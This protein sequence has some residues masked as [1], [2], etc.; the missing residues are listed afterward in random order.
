MVWG[1]GLPA[2][3]DHNGGIFQCFCVKIADK[4]A[5]GAW[6]GPAALEKLGIRPGYGAIFFIVG[7]NPMCGLPPDPWAL[8]MLTVSWEVVPQQPF[9][10]Q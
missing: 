5:R 7:T 6:K 3:H 10:G 2:E 1:M 9:F 4:K 8:L